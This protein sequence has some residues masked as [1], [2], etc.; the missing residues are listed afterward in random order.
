MSGLRARISDTTRSMFHV[1]HIHKF[2]HNRGQ[3]ATPCGQNDELGASPVSRRPRLSRLV[4]L[5]ALASLILAGCG[6]VAEAAGWSGPVKLA[7]GSI[8]VQVKPGEVRAV[9]P[10]SGDERWHF[11][12]SVKDKKSSKRVSKPVKGTFYAAPVLDKD[13]IYLVSYEGHVARVDR[14]EG[15]AIGNPWTAELGANVV[16]TPILSGGRLYVATEGGEIVVVGTEDGAIVSRYRAGSGRIWGG[17]VVSGE[18]L[19]TPNLDERA[20]YAIRLSDGQQAWRTDDA[21]S[22]SDVTSAG[23]NL[24]IGGIDASLRAIDAAGGGVRWRFETD[25]WVAGAPLVAGDTIYVGSMRGSIYALTLDGQQRQKYTLDV[26]KAEFRATPVIAGGHLIA[27]SRRGVIVG[28]NPSTLEQQWRQEIPDV[29][30]DATPLVVDGQVFLITT[31]HA[32]IRVDAATGA[33]RLIS[34]PSK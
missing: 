18:N 14:G 22:V 12:N 10:A 7:D 3:T 27:V 15:G 4:A 33:H 26:E 30:I 13:R 24:L 28:L 16:A 1:K 32:L 11:P 20:I 6:G 5:A 21:A 31:K 29:R 23:P 17:A 34:A 25:G 2:I 9:D 19:I 8:L